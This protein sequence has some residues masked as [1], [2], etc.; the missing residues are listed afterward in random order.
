LATG[1]FG[2]DSPAHGA[3]QPE[4]KTGESIPPPLG[5]GGSPVK[6]GRPTAEAGEEATRKHV[7]EEGDPIWGFGWREAHRCGLMAVVSVAEGRAPVR[8]RRGARRR[9]WR[10]RRGTPGHGGAWR[11]EDEVGVGHRGLEPGRSSWP[12]KAVG[13]RGVGAVRWREEESK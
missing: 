1:L 7:R 10:G 9:G 11:G 3:F 8:G 12:R 4:A 6:S 13:S 2:P 5:A